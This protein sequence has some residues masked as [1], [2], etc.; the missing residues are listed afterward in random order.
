MMVGVLSDGFDH[1]SSRSRESGEMGAGHTDGGG[2]GRGK[3][4]GDGDWG[5][6][7]ELGRMDD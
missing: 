4:E 6:I 1:T 2:R 5:E 7:E 3:G